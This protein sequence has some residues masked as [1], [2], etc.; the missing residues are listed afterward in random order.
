MT[1]ILRQLAMIALFMSVISVP[2]QAEIY[3][4]VDAEGNVIFTDQKPKSGPSE[5]VEVGPVLTVPSTKVKP[6][7]PKPKQ[8][9]QANRYKSLNIVSPENEQSFQNPERITITAQARP[10]A[11]SGDRFRL[12]WDGSSLLESDSPNFT[13]EMPDRGAHSIQIE[14]MDKNGKTLI[15]SQP[16][17]IY[18]HR[19]SVFNNPQHKPDDD[20]DD[21]GGPAVALLNAVTSLLVDKA[22][23]N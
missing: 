7:P 13:V 17:T 20:M 9:Q 16:R 18:V 8:E 5:T 2:V 23:D 10:S 3:R 19:A 12:I 22:T 1:A 14:I 6:L 11:R 21:V 4:T 15:S